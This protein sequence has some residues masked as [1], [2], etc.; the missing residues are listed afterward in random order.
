M[1]FIE[2]PRPE[3]GHGEVRL[4]DPVSTLQFDHLTDQIDRARGIAALLHREV[5]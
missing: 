1:G 5:E 2:S 4:E 3:Q